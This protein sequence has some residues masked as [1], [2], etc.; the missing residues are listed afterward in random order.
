[1]SFKLLQLLRPSR[2]FI[3]RFFPWVVLLSAIVLIAVEDNYQAERLIA[4]DHASIPQP[5]PAHVSRPDDTYL[6]RIG[7]DD[8]SSNE[9][10]KAPLSRYTL[11]S[12]WKSRDWQGFP[13]GLDRSTPQSSPY[14]ELT[15]D[16][17]EIPAHGVEFSLRVLESR[18]QVPELAV[19]SN[20]RLAGI[21]QTW[22]A[23][24]SG[25]LF[26]QTYRLYIPKELLQSGD[27]T[28]RLA[29]LNHPYG[30]DARDLSL[31]WD[32]LALEALKAPASEPI[33]GR[34]I[35]MGSVLQAGDS[36]FRIVP[37][38][39]EHAPAIFKWLGIAYS[40]NT[41]R[42]TYWSDVQASQP[43]ELQK[44]LLETYRDLNLSVV[45]NRLNTA[46]STLSPDRSLFTDG[47]RNLDQFFQDFGHLFQYYEIDNEPSL[48]KRSKAVNIAI[49][50]YLNRIKK[51]VKLVAP[52]W[53]YWPS[54]G[55]PS[56]WERDV[57][58]RR[59]VESL[60]EV[61]NGHSYGSSYNDFHGGS[62]VENLKTYGDVVND[63]FPREFLVTE[64]GTANS[65]TDS[66]NGSSQ[67]HA[68]VFDRILRAHIA[69]T[70]RF[71]QHALF[72]GE[73]SMLKA[74]ENWSTHKPENLEIYPGVNGE[75]PRLKTYRRLA[76]AYATHGKPLAYRYN[77][78][79]NYKNVYFRA[80]DTAGLEPLIG[81]GGKANKILL[82]FVNFE[83][84]EQ[85]LDVNVT[86]PQSGIYQGEGIGAGNT[87]KTAAKPV[88]L[89]AKP[90]LNLK[91]TLGPRESTQYILNPPLP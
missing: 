47:K 89:T 73:Y 10:G 49:A 74:I 28:L 60:T 19:Y 20:G 65:H 39:I 41:L 56:G 76:I 79:A 68:A 64:T 36:D 46:Q 44:K 61:T 50:E 71:M 12:N 58:H 1:M 59:D 40:G 29:L 35:Y 9:F 2:K 66:Y 37:A 14:T 27:N 18:K 21:I 67:P 22:F 55:Q 15:Y 5:M 42:A 23:E 13:S 16:L 83:N 38:M 77:D 17:S 75:E 33:H 11:P 32:Y 63:G 84:S 52:G 72:G 62:F 70:D 91:V 6:W 78:S 57:N 43:P 45:A 30:Q 53:A 34:K 82:N 3:S 51:H 81:S 54:G 85:T 8:L 26:R 88:S 31:K 7:K 80:V 69:V 90:D 48:F 87:Y 24:Q 86:L 4:A 25:L